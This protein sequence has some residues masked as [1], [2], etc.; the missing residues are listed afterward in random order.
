M[1]FW[2]TQ[3]ISIYNESKLGVAEMFLRTLKGI[4]YSKMI[5]KLNLAIWMIV[6]TIIQ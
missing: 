3:H 1:I 4:M 2:Y 5:A 6:N